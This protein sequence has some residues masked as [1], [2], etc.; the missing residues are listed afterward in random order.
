MITEH[1]V[2]LAWATG[3]GVG[4]LA[5]LRWGSRAM[6]RSTPGLVG[7]SVSWTAAYIALDGFGLTALGL[8]VVH[9]GFA[10]LVGSAVGV[11]ARIIGRGFDDGDDGG[12]GGGGGGWDDEP[13]AP[14]DPDPGGR[15]IPRPVSVSD[16]TTADFLRETADTPAPAEP[17]PL[18][19]VGR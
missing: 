15:S 14:W 5:Y 13:P 9:L 18:I 2:P 12:G 3:G 1:L 17:S 4:C 7:Y 10:Y 6:P 8:P 19:P 16:L 11:I